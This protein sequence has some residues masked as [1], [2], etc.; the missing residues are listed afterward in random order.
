MNETMIETLMETKAP[1]EMQVMEATAIA[2][3]PRSTS[4]QVEGK[5]TDEHVAL[6]KRTICKD[7]TDDELALFVATAKRM[8]LDPFARQIFAVKRNTKDGPVMSI[9][10]SIDGFR[11]I[12]ERTGKYEGQVGPFWCG[13]DGKWVDVWLSDKPPSAAKVGVW[14]TGAREPTWA[15]ARYESY[16]Q[17]GQSGITPIWAKMPDL[18]ISKCSESLALRKAFPSEL[19]GLYTESEMSGQQYI[20]NPVDPDAMTDAQE[21]ECHEIIDSV[22]GCRTVEEIDKLEKDLKERKLDDVQKKAIWPTYKAYKAT[23]ISA[24]GR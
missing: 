20:E 3:A 11:L 17:R 12:A 10:V 6:I 4:M 1:T 2:Q 5:F 19:S 22:L 8:G 16:V 23:L 15:V 14:K 9:Q 21:K 24:K 7:A 13:K 18:M